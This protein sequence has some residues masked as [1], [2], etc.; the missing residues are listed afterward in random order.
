MSVE[1][2]RSRMISFRLSPEEYDRFSKMCSGRGA[3]SVSDM[4]RVALLNLIAEEQEFDP[5]ALEV[6]DLRSQ[7]KSV[8]GE[9]ERISDLLEGR[10]VSQA[11]DP[12]PFPI[13]TATPHTSQ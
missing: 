13:V 2:R 8:A 11:G 9:L 6:R 3:R 4:V 10:K 7:L 12:N 1:L 5:L